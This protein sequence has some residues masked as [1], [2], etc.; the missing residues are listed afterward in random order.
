MPPPWHVLPPKIKL[1]SVEYF[2][3]ENGL[4][5]KCQLMAGVCSLSQGEAQ[6]GSSRPFPFEL[7]QPLHLRL[8]VTALL[9]DT[10]LPQKT[11]RMVNQS[12]KSHAEIV[13]I[14]YPGGNA[15]LRNQVKN[16][17]SLGLR[18]TGYASVLKTARAHSQPCRKLSP[19][20]LVTY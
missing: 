12:R 14:S 15:F 7:Q 11:Q 17:P 13:L 5:V 2:T 19:A 18:G 4:P 9:E 10:D 8:A 6:H 20:K 3:A 1:N 16:A